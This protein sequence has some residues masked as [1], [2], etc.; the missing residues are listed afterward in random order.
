MVHFPRFART[1]LCIHDAVIWFGHIGFPHSDIPGSMPACGSPKL[2][3]ACHVLH[4]LLL[5]RHPPCALSSLTTKFTQSTTALQPSCAKKFHDAYALLLAP[6]YAVLRP[7]GTPAESK[8]LIKITLSTRLVVIYPML[9][10]CQKSSA[11]EGVPPGWVG[12]LSVISRQL[13]VKPRTEDLTLPRLPKVR[14]QATGSRYRIVRLSLL[15]PNLRQLSVVGAQVSEN[16][17]TELQF[18][19]RSISRPVIPT[20]G[21]LTDNRQLITDNWFWWS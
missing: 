13:S 9:F 17:N 21:Y 1:S 8:A 2:I 15:T 5:P 12:Q 4:R 14:R 20:I 3:A 11:L 16:Q 7:Q 19:I 10:S 6:R 18:E